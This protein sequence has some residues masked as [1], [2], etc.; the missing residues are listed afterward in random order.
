[1]LLDLDL[2]LVQFMY[3]ECCAHVVN[4]VKS[5]EGVTFS[6]SFQKS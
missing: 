5:S 2:D 6:V 4:L 3:S 1:M